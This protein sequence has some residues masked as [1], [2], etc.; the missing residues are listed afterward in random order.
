MTSVLVGEGAGDVEGGEQGEDVGLQ[1]L[2]EALEEGEDDA[3]E[4][5]HATAAT[6]A[7]R[8]ALVESRYAPPRMNSSS[9]R[10][11]ANMLS[12]RRRVSVIG[13]MMKVETNSIGASRT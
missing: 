11:P 7:E 12:V 6:D 2:D 4:Q 9:T 5:R 13:R 10:W 8:A 1:Q 3:A